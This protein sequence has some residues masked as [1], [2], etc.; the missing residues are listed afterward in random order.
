[1][2]LKLGDSAPNFELTGQDGKNHSLKDL[3]GKTTLIYFYPKD[4][5]PGCTIQA[6]AL[7]DKFEDLQQVGIDVIGV[8]KDDTASHR[9]FAAN[10]KLPF[11]ILADT[12]HTMTENYGSW[13]EHS[14]FGKKYFGTERSAVIIGPKLTILAIWAKIAP[15]KTV[16]E[17]LKWAQSQ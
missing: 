15:L 16:P 11:V 14:M 17:V 5:T 12:N 7:R 13:S 3:A 9:K 8:S 6:C 4:E 1:M 2:G 10:H